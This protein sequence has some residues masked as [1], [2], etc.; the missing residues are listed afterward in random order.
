MKTLLVP[1]DFSEI[2]SNAIDYAV[3]L[4]K[5]THAKIILF[6][7]YHVPVVA[8]EALVA[9]PDLAQIEKFAVDNLKRIESMIR[10]KQ[11]HPVAIE[12]VCKCGFAVEEI[13]LFVK[14]H[15]TDLI[16]MG[17]HGAGYL[18]EKL[19]GSV[20]TSLIR[21]S[22]CPVLAI[23]QHVKFKIPKRIVLACDYKH[24]HKSLLW[25]LKEMATLFNAHI[26][27]LN[28]AKESSEG[29]DLETAVEGLKL[30]TAF[31]QID[32]SFHSVTNDEVVN[33]INDY[34]SKMHMDMVVMIPRQRSFF[35]NLF[36]GSQTK[37][38]AF[39]TH[40]PLLALHE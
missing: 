16:V 37:R 11:G 14:E 19:I 26:Y 27:I 33:G 20:T 28:V 38:M 7:A 25:P 23:D 18:T 39:H 40:V 10:I 29:M 15:K 12:C 21:E 6:H 30:D 5:I 17:M 8:T 32:H 34:V 9:V 31:K 22:L 36:S 4:S 1:T 3:E 24:I 13:N 2:S 35:E